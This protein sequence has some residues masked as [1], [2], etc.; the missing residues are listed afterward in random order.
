ML[1]DSKYIDTRMKVMYVTQFDQLSDWEEISDR[2]FPEALRNRKIFLE[3]ANIRQGM[4]V[5][6]LGCGTG[7]LTVDAGLYQAV[8]ST[9]WVTATEPSA[10][11][12][13]RLHRKLYM[14]NIKNVSLETAVA[15]QIPYGDEEFDACVGV[16]FFHFTDN[17]KALSEMKRVTRKGGS[18][19]LFETLDFNL[20]VP[21]FRE[22]FNEF[23]ELAQKRG[24]SAPPNYLYKPGQL[25]AMFKEYG[26]LDVNETQIDTAATFDVPANVVRFMVQGVGLFQQEMVLLPWKARI[27]LIDRLMEKGKEICNKYSLSERTIN[28][29]MA[30]VKGTVV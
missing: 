17:Q 11:M 13:N 19:A 18:I 27:E 23:F 5:L 24:H 15:E 22:W 10:G 7:A 16:A 30:L 9:G 29:P 12:I 28:F 8:G 6:E 4:Q 20:N 2:L 1:I 3:Y 26:L 14:Q 21:F 25:G